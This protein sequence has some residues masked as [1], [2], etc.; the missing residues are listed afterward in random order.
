MRKVKVR[1]VCRDGKIRTIRMKWSTFMKKI[2]RN[3]V[4]KISFNKK[5]RRWVW[6]KT[7]IPEV[8]EKI[9]KKIEKIEK[10]AIREKLEP[11]VFKVHAKIRYEKKGKPYKNFYLDAYTYI[12]ASNEEEAKQIMEDLIRAEFPDF[13]KIELHAEEIKEEEAENFGILMYKHRKEERWR[14]RRLDT[15]V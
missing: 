7:M 12:K 15:Y 9:E 6:K 11:K 13:P 1:M 10:K 2:K 3:E 5:L 14:I 8:I 4:A